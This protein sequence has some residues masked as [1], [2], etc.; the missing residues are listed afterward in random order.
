[1][2]NFR[3]ER[4]FVM[5]DGPVPGL[6]HT[7]GIDAVEFAWHNSNQHAE[8]LGVTPLDAFT[9]APFEEPE[10]SDASEGLKTVR[11]L[12]SLY[13]EWI[14]KGKNPYQYRPDV[15][16]KKNAVLETVEEVLATA[17]SLGRRFF[18]AARDLG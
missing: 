18:L 5:L 2:A 14:A 4:L 16:T 8:S 6:D 10:W 11:A 13:A 15:I 1:M 9:F 17:D 12:R 3:M 7:K